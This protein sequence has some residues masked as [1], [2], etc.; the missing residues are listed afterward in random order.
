MRDRRVIYRLT[1]LAAAMSVGHHVDHVIRGNAIG[2]PL[3]PDVNAFTVSLAIYPVLATGLLLT[4]RGWVG[5]G[6]WALLSGGGA[7]FV[8]A[9]HFGPFAVEPPQLVHAGHDSAAVGWVAFA[10]LI[11]FVGVLIVTCV[12]E[13]R[14]WYNER[15]MGYS[16]SEPL[17][18]GGR[19]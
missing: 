16:V 3:T 19:P 4:W 6:F 2:W 5:P 9:V 1:V 11:G 7:A 13:T 12:Y 10:W 14:A 17:A 8:S 15:R 18:D